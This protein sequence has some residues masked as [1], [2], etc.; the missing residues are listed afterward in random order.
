[1]IDH[2]EI[3]ESS[4]RMG[5]HPANVERDYVFGWLLKSFYENDFLAHRL[6]FK[7]GNC[8]RKAF[9]PETRFSG[10]LDFSLESALDLE[11]TQAEINRAC[12]TA[13]AACGVRFDTGR[14]TLQPDAFL[15]DTRRSYKGSI[16]FQDFYGNAAS[17]IISIRVDLTE[18]DRIYL[19]TVTR[20]L[21]HIYS[22]A[23]N[24]RADLRCMALEELLANKL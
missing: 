15:D 5:V 20:P 9:Y 3:D 16:Y 23:D 7:G 6:I 22:D 14:N 24:C 10:D 11:R 8:M 17:V 1:M 2:D 21:I 13:Q 12:E 4:E 19:P 18:F